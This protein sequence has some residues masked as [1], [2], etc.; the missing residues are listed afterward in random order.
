M[1][2]FV[3]HNGFELDDY[4]KFFHFDPNDNVAS[5]EYGQAAIF[6]KNYSK[7]KVLFCFFFFPAFDFATSI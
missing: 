4:Y 2:L 5:N 3:F 7:K 6:R 1:T